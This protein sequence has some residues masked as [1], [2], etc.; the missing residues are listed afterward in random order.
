MATIY[1]PPEGFEPPDFDEAFVDGRYDRAK[2][3]EVHNA[4]F[5]RLRAEAARCGNTGE[6]VGKIIYF[7]IADGSA[8]YMVWK[9]KPLQLL[10]LA[11]HDA[12]SIPAAHAR[13][14]K[15]A[16]VRAMVDRADAW[17]DLFA[18]G[19]DWWA[20][21]PVGTVLHYDNGFEQYVR[22]EV[23]QID[24]K[25]MLRPTALVGNVIPL[26]A[27][28]EQRLERGWGTTDIV[29]RTAWGEV[30]YG[31][32][33]RKVMDGEAWQPSTSCVVESP[34]YNA[35]RRKVDP[36]GLPAIDF[37]ALLP[38]PDEAKLA[39]EATCRLVNEVARLANR[40]NDRDMTDD[41]RIAAI[42]ELVEHAAAT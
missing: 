27:T 13:G 8:A 36:R 33:A 24:G 6:T 37:D 29:G 7:P 10:H 1:S 35:E 39:A 20:S 21:Q 18:K 40:L 4:Y 11:I 34:E 16:D 22:G 9:E 28:T 2:D 12:W 14:I 42:R 19:D 30:K 15:L 38:Q 25:R 23:V 26:G 41:E 5:E 17:T 3:D 32:H 31:Y